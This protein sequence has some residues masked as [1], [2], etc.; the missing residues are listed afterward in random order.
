MPLFNRFIVCTALFASLASSSLFAST[1]ES[2]S[3]F[4]I[5]GRRGTKVEPARP[6]NVPPLVLADLVHRDVDS[7]RTLKAAS[8]LKACKDAFAAIAW[9]CEDPLPR[10]QALYTSTAQGIGNTWETKYY[11]LEFK[12]LAVRVLLRLM[13]DPQVTFPVRL[14]GYER[15]QECCAHQAYAMSVSTASPDLIA[16]ASIALV[17]YTPAGEIC[18]KSCTR[19]KSEV[20]FEAYTHL[21]ENMRLTK[22][23][24]LMQLLTDWDHTPHLQGDEHFTRQDCIETLFGLTWGRRFPADLRSRVYRTL[25]THWGHSH[26]FQIADQDIDPAYL[27]AFLN[28]THNTH[29]A[30]SQATSSSS[31]APMDAHQPF[32]TPKETVCPPCLYGI[33]SILK[34]SSLTHPHARL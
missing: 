3:S 21:T 30:L 24:V 26:T 7:P 9:R 32:L 31:S 29:G 5:W 16:K 2:D 11:H 18:F 19:S 4:M 13:A 10:L 20:L 28:K 23:K 27:E 34:I 33:S 12:R 15:T 25:I 6:T 17:K 8:D 14:G 22:A 1:E